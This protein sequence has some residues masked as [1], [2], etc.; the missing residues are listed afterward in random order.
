MQY[1]MCADGIEVILLEW[2]GVTMAKTIRIGLLENIF[3]KHFHRRY[4]ILGRE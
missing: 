3:F 4:L 2:N 1:C